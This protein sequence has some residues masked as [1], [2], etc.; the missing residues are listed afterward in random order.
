MYMWVCKVVYNLYMYNIF[1]YK[2][3]VFV[4]VLFFSDKSILYLKK[5]ANYLDAF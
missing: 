5:Y 3:F 4:K 1:K 2:F